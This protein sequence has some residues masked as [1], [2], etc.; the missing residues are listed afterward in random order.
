[1]FTSRP[2]FRALTE[3]LT[4]NKIQEGFAAVAFPEPFPEVA[5]NLIS[6]LLKNN[7]QERL[8]AK[9]YSD[10]KA[11]PFFAGINWDTLSTTN[12]PTAQGPATKY[13]W[14]E[15]IIKE[16]EERV[17]M[18]KKE[19]RE[20]WKAFLKD[21]EN[22]VEHG[23]VI[24]KRKMSRK[25]RM[26]LLTDAP[27]LVYLDPRRMEQ[28]GEIPFDPAMKVEIRDDVIWR[29]VVPKRIYELEDVQREATRWQEA[30]EKM[31]AANKS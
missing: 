23:M 5:K 27:R 30:I 1:M 9:S 18:E 15:D 26:L 31:K 11:H 13:V 17:A 7:P 21:D 16:E 28:K 8:G 3:Y 4:M 6:Q 14:K 24:K 20:K 22:I 12:P 19:F 29:I 10:L 2:P 25:K